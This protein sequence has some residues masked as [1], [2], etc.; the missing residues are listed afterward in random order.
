MFCFA[1][2]PAT[3]LALELQWV[4]QLMLCEKMMHLGSSQMQGIHESNNLFYQNLH[5]NVMLSKL[6]I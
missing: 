2:W 1:K 4:L 5:C 3:P 6:Q